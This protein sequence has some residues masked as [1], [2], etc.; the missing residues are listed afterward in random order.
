MDG[1]NYFCQIKKQ[2]TLKKTKAKKTVTY[3]QKNV[4]VCLNRS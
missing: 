2:C 1:C 3:K 4:N